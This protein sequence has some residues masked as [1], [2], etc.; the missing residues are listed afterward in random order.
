MIA[1]TESK[2]DVVSEI[3]NMRK[4]QLFLKVR[5]RAMENGAGGERLGS[6]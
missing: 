5:L 6:L 1:A 4:V 2:A 3:V